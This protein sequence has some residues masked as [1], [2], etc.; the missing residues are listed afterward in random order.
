M[1]IKWSSQSGVVEVVIPLLGW[2][3]VHLNC[4]QLEPVIVPCFFFTTNGHQK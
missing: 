2:Q 1:V 4:L 3:D